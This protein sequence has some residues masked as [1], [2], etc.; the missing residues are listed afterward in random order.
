M[1]NDDVALPLREVSGDLVVE[2]PNALSQLENVGVCF[3]RT[4]NI[5]KF[6]EDDSAKLF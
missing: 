4:P 2:G 1:A 5:W 6:Y 3:K